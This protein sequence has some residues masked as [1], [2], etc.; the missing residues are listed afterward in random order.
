CCEKVR[1]DAFLVSFVEFLQTICEQ[2]ECGCRKDSSCLSCFQLLCHI[3]DTVPGR[4]HVV[5]DDHIFSFY[6]IAKEFM[7]DDRIAPV[8]D[9]GVITAFV[10]HSHVKS[11]HVC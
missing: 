8:Y 6:R 4:D 5:Q 3:D 7:S 2:A 9:T 1:D 11:Q 10:E